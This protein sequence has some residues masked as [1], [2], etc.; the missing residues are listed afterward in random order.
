[1][2]MY[3]YLVCFRLQLSRVWLLQHNMHSILG[4]AVQEARDKNTWNH[5][6][7]WRYYKERQEISN[8]NSAQ[9]LH[10]VTQH[11][12]SDHIAENRGKLFVSFTFINKTSVDKGIASRETKCI[13]MIHY[14]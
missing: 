10:V 7:Y 2:Y 4:K 9:G 12:M 11:C 14:V 8:T 5:S 1:M 6:P 13:D 3:M